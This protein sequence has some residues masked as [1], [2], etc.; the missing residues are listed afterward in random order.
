MSDIVGNLIAYQWLAVNSYKTA[1]NMLE[2]EAD[3]PQ[4]RG[5]PGG[6]SVWADIHG[7][8]RQADRGSLPKTDN[9]PT[10]RIYP[11]L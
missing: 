5:L 8:I 9:P 7:Y 4:I 11:L 1:G 6:L 3:R 10:R 2:T